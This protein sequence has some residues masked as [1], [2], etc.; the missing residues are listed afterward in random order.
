MQLPAPTASAHAG[1]GLDGRGLVTGQLDAR[2][3]LRAGSGRRCRRPTW[4]PPLTSCTP[5]CTGAARRPVTAVP[6][7]GPVRAGN[8][9]HGSDQQGCSSGCPAV[10]ITDHVP[11]VRVPPDYADRRG[12]AAI[13]ARGDAENR[14]KLDPA[15]PAQR[16][17]AP[18]AAAAEAGL[19]GPGP[20][21]CPA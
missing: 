16:A 15:P 18:A 21:R 6:G 4:P 2:S 11:A 1:L 8:L 14:G 10:M 17:A 7:S 19:G 20:A 9:V 5:L 12:I 13:A 3:A